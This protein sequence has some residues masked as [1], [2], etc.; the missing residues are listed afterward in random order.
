[1][2]ITMEEAVEYLED[3]MEIKLECNGYTYEISASD[4][5][6]G[7]DVEDGYISS[8][9]GNCIYGDAEYIIGE[10]IRSLIKNS[11]GQPVTINV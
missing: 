1:M 2:V 6:I 5:W 4:N 9:L 7:G 3:G 8:V 10:S 11:N